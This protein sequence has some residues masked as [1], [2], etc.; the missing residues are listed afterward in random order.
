MCALIRMCTTLCYTCTYNYLNLGYMHVTWYTLAKHLSNSCTYTYVQLKNFIQKAKFDPEIDNNYYARSRQDLQNSTGDILSDTTASYILSFY[1]IS[2]VFTILITA[3]LLNIYRSTKHWDKKLKS[4]STISRANKYTQSKIISIAFVT[5]IINIYTVTLDAVAIMSINQSDLQES[6]VLNSIPKIVV[7]IDSVAISIWL[8]FFTLGIG[9]LI[10]GCTQCI[11]CTD[12][13]QNKALYFF[14]ISTVGPLHSMV[15][16]LPYI[17]IAYLNDA[18]YATSIFIYYT[19][20]VFILFGSLDLIFGT[21]L[22]E[23]INEWP[24]SNGKQQQQTQQPTG[25]PKRPPDQSLDLLELSSDQH[26]Q[27]LDQR[28]QLQTCL[29]R[30]KKCWWYSNC[31]CLQV[32]IRTTFRFAVLIL[33][34]TPLIVILMGMVTAAIVVVPISR[35]LSDAPNRLLG[36]YQTAIILIGAYIFYKKFIKRKTTIKSVLKNRNKKIFDKDK[37]WNEKSDNDKLET[38]YEHLI[39]IVANT[40]PKAFSRI[41]KRRNSA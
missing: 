41:Q 33:V 1:I 29:A 6:N 35:S 20:T 13:L 38:F 27:S 2:F 36:F 30:L 11:C 22:Q 24:A 10:H 18:A 15:I 34:F 25:Q 28:D 16:H 32:K 9:A 3:L 8:L 4:L 39:K 14:A 21:C 17:F 19:I 23:I 31:R 37:K 5:F 7:T 40:N 12:P 26:R